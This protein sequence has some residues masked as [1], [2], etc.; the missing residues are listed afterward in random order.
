M[1]MID[2]IFAE[3]S[4]DAAV[5]ARLNANLWEDEAFAVKLYLRSRKPIGIGLCAN[6]E[7]QMPD[8]TTDFLRRT[9]AA[10]ADRLKHPVP[11]F[12]TGDVG[13]REDFDVRKCGD[14]INEIA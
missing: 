6:E 12:E 7:E 4:L 11:P 5:K 14:A 3:G 1:P 8:G 13:V 9:G 2:V 10:P